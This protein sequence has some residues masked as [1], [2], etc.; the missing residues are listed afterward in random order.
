MPELR[1]A[2]R[3]EGNELPVLRNG[4]CNSY[5]AAA[6][7]ILSAKRYSLGPWGVDGEFG[8]A[9]MTAVQNFQTRNGLPRNG[10]V[11][12]ETWAKLF[13]L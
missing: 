12:K 10:V 2:P 3:R 1:G 4:M 6:Q 13:E 11:D 8:T 7:G 9:T 5:V